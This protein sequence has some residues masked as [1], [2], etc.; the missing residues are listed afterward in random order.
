MSNFRGFARNEFTRGLAL[1]L[2]IM[3]LSSCAT[4]PTVPVRPTVYTHAVGDSTPKDHFGPGKTVQ[5]TVY[6]YQGNTATFYIR[7]LFTGQIV[8]KRTEC[9]P[10]ESNG[11]TLTIDT[12]PSGAYSA[13][14]NIDGDDVGFWNFSVYQKDFRL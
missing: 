6:G 8:Y 9:I 7:D 4:A 3:I 1:L 12:L 5:I 14:V 2:A 11:L 10:N 13:S